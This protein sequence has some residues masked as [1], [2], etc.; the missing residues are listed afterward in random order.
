M[1]WS[2]APLVGWLFEPE[3]ESRRMVGAMSAPPCPAPPPEPRPYIYIGIDGKATTGRALEDRA[4][5]AEAA[6]EAE[7]VARLVAEEND[8][9][10][11]EYLEIDAKRIRALQA[12]L[13]AE[14]QRVKALEEA[15]AKADAELDRLVGEGLPAL[16][17][18]ND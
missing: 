2:M 3:R 10:S 17:D 1:S 14:Q 5:A 12:D 7:K 9:V 13:A 11:R 15:L 6:L 16:E 18:G 8:K 4:L